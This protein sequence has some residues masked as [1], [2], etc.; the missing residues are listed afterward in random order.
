MKAVVN[1]INIRRCL[2]LALAIFLMVGCSANPS[3][4]V[5]SYSAPT[6]PDGQACVDECTH[7]KVNCNE[8][9]TVAAPQC[10]A[11][12]QEKARYDFKKYAEVQSAS[13]QP[14]SQPLLSFYHPEN[15]AHSGCG[16]EANYKVCY[17][18]CGTRTEMH[19][20][21]AEQ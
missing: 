16:C 5:Y 19:S 18:L 14:V 15:C 9:C 1:S 13:G 6:S 12:E 21:V 8:Q 7:S 20:P 17:Q 4:T 11:Q 2:G 10:L 3:S